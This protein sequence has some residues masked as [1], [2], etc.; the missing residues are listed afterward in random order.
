[1]KSRARQLLVEVSRRHLLRGFGAA[2]FGGLAAGCATNPVTGQSELMLLSEE[3]ELQLGKQAFSQLAWQQGGPLR[4]DSAAQGYLAGIVRKLHQ[5]S[6]RSNLPV[7]F[8]LESASEPNAWAI[9]GHTAMNRGLLQ[10]LENEAQFAFVMGHEMGH[11]AA[12]HS[13]ARQSRA[14]LGST[15]V[16]ILGVAA[17]VVGLGALGGL[18]VGAAGA[19]TQL[20]LLSYDRG[21]ELQADTLGALY[22]GRAGYDPREATRS[23]EVLNRAIDAHLANLGQRR[24]DPSAMSQILST[25]PRHEERVAEIEAYVK[26]LPASEVRIEGDGRHADRWLRQTEP[27]RRLAP[28]Y[29]RYDRALQAFG[30]AFQANEQK[31][32]SVVRQKLAEAQREIDAAIQLADQAQFAT[33]QGYLLAVQ[34]RRGE[35]R[36]AFNRAVALYPGYQPAIRALS[37]IGS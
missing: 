13:A 9:P 35:A 31:Q 32:D 18:A 36:T 5:V 29:A 11:V 24:G 7:D 12:R 10:Y 30:Q 20:L 16:G 4:I 3:E 27:I 37:R 34:G 6:H 17:D 14:T 33:L 21:Q 25:H 19:G 28:A 22:M 8:T 2:A 1:M 15:G 23:H 26:T